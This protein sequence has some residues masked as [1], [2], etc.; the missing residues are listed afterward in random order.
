MIER[1]SRKVMRDIWTEENKFGAYL[2]VELSNAKAWAELGVVPKEDLP[3]L[4]K[5]TFK[6]NGFIMEIGRAHV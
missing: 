3:K 1:Y 2:K 6:K 4:D 5:A